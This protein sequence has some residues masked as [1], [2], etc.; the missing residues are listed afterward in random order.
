MAGDES[1]NVVIDGRVRTVAAGTDVKRLLHLLGE[2]D[3]GKHLLVELNGRLV[4]A[5]EYDVTILS[6]G[7]RVEIIY[8][9]F[10]G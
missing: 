10:G 3:D 1:I 2:P 5:K 6:E 8:P 7:D 9:A 4:R